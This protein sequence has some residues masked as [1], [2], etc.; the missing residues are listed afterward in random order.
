MSETGTL[1]ADHRAL[2]DDLT[3]RAF[4]D[5]TRRIASTL[6]AVL[7]E[8]VRDGLFSDTETQVI[9]GYLDALKASMDAL[10]MKYMVAARTP[11]P[12]QRHLTIDVH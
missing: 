7:S 9:T 5:Q 3:A 6:P 2:D 4:I 8:T 10:A 1:D 11:G 12:L